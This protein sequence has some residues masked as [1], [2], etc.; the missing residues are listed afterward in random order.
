MRTQVYHLEGSIISYRTAAEA[1]RAAYLISD[2]TGANGSTY[3][4]FFMEQIIDRYSD[5]QQLRFLEKELKASDP[6][7]E[8]EDWWSMLASYRKSLRTAGDH[9][10]Q[11]VDYR[12]AAK[13]SFQRYYKILRAWHC[14]G[15]RKEGLSPLVEL[16]E[17]NGLGYGAVDPLS[18]EHP[19]SDLHGKASDQWR[20]GVEAG[21][22]SYGLVHLLS[23]A[24]FTSGSAAP[25]LE[26]AV[27]LLQLPFLNGFEPSLLKGMRAELTAA[28][29]PFR[30]AMDKW[31]AAG[32]EPADEE[33]AARA[34]LEVKRAALLL[35]E[36]IDT[37]PALRYEGV[38]QQL[39]A[40]R[41]SVRD[42][43]E[44]ARRCGTMGAETWAAL[45]PYTDVAARRVPVL[46]IRS[47]EQPSSSEEP[48]LLGTF[49]KRIE[50]D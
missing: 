35:Q 26:G 39:I 21:D 11:A 28:G 3:V 30:S 27:P 1:V 20:V 31:V 22:E 9:S 7:R 43:W 45:Q 38:G 23:D 24:F 18:P 17:Q 37:H 14:Q 5:A 13:K 33:A 50:I 2:H 15:R 16:L 4:F 29:A 46:A 32:S 6:D 49:L 40:F 48:G 25:F 36:A 12:Y 44:Q 19:D 41:M 8:L 47:L 10:K 34:A 42:L